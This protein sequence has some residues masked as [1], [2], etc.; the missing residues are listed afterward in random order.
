[1]SFL[2]LPI[3]QELMPLKGFIEA[4]VVGHNKGFD[5]KTFAQGVAGASPIS[6]GASPIYS[7]YQALFNNYDTFFNDKVWKG[8]DVAPGR[9]YTADTHFLY[10]ELGQLFPDAISPVKLERAVSSII[11][12]SNSVMAAGMYSADWAAEQMNALPAEEN[13]RLVTALTKAFG[14]GRFMRET[15]PSYWAYEMSAEA[16]AAKEAEVGE[17]QMIGKKYGRMYAD[18]VGS[19]NFGSGQGAY[20]E[21]FEELQRRGKVNSPKQVVAAVRSFRGAKSNK[22]DQQKKILQPYYQEVQNDTGDEE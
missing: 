5:T 19:G 1:M 12:Q 14:V 10:R 7:S 13:N 9:Q 16:K 21:M 22:L 20:A 11:P 18:A 17:A 8:P 2:W 4:V 3:P 15:K 6:V